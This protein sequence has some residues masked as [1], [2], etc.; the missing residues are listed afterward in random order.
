[1]IKQPNQQAQNTHQQTNGP[2]YLGPS[3]KLAYVENKLGHP[4]T[5]SPIG[6]TF[7]RGIQQQVKQQSFN[8]NSMPQLQHQTYYVSG[9]VKNNGGLAYNDPNSNIE[10][11]KIVGYSSAKDCL[12]KFSQELETGTMIRGTFRWL[13]GV[14]IEDIAYFVEHETVKKMNHNHR[15]PY[16]VWR[17]KETNEN[18][19]GT[20]SWL[21]LQ[22]QGGQE[23]ET[24]PH[25]GDAYQQNTQDGVPPDVDL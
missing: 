22:E 11:K 20:L 14:K 7:T 12:Y 9:T 25:V 13:Y 3:S 4:V 24:F 1:M 6:N 8:S 17:L 10:Y 23:Q 21:D 15:R 2:L 16:S 18:V 5:P 19:Q